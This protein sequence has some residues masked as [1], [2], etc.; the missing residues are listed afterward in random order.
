MQKRSEEK[1]V[2]TVE[3]MQ[4]VASCTV[5]DWR[6]CNIFSIVNHDRPYVDEDEQDYICKLLQWE[7]EWKY[8]IRKRLGVAVHGMEGMRREWSWHNPL[9]M[10]LVDMLVESRM[11]LGSVDPVYEK[12]GEGNEKWELEVIVP[13]ART[14]LCG[15]IHLAVTPYFGE[16]EWYREDG[17][18]GERPQSL[19][20]LETDLVLQ[21]FRMVERGLVK[22]EDV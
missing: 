10:R 17:H 21:I 15:V 9:M 20:N 2:L 1:R 4:S 16:E 18:D 6:V 3:M 13:Q 19:L 12:I 7:N 5:D 11:M 22:D 14:V 8:V